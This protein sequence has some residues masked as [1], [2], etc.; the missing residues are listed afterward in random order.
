MGREGEE[1]E[2]RETGGGGK[3][4]ERKVVIVI[5]RHGERGVRETQHLF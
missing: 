2:R 4:G 5:E 3:E 1:G